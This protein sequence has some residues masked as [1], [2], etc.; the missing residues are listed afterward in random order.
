[1]VC[2]SLI[3][4]IILNFVWK[5]IAYM[6]Y[7]AE[8]RVFFVLYFFLNLLKLFIYKHIQNTFN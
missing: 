5:R 6:V 7:V 3:R 1:M 4:R 2:F 8:Y